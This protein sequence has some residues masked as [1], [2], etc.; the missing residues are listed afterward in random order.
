MF[1]FLT[2]L[3]AAVVLGLLAACGGED[4]ARSESAQ[5][6]SCAQLSDLK[7]AAADIGLQTGGASVSAAESLSADAAPGSAAAGYCLVT[8]KILPVDPLAPDIEFKVALPT[9]WNS[10]GLM[11]GGGGYNGTIPNV[12]GTMLNSLGASPL[13]R[14]YAVFA[15]DGGHQASTLPN[16]AAFG[17]NEEAYRN[18]MGDALKKTRDVA[19]VLIKAS[20]GREPSKSYFL[21]SSNGGREALTV[22]ARWPEDWD[23]VVALYP[24]RRFTSTVVAGAAVLHAFAE[25]GALPNR[26][27]RGLLRR[28]ALEA[29]DALDGLADGLIGN[30]N[31]CNARFDPATASLHGVPLRCAGGDDLGDSCLSDLQLS[32]L[33]VMNGPFHWNFALASGETSFPGWPVYTSDL[34]IESPIPAL[35][36]LQLA[37]ATLSIGLLPPG[38]PVTEGMSFATGI[39]DGH[40]RYVVGR[41][42]DFN[43]FDFNPY[44]GWP[45]ATRLSELSAVDAADTE[46]AKFAAKGGKLLMM[47]GTEDMT[48]SPRTSELYYQGLQAS[49][50]GPTVESFVRYYLVPGFA[51]SISSTFNAQWDQLSALE[52]W[53]ERDI[54]PRSNQIVIDSVGVPGRSRPLCPY[55]TFAKY[56]GSG[57]V[58]TAAS[59]VCA[60][61]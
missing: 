27:K 21:G 42:P 32:A 30:V 48:V 5:M 7:I 38:F 54:D 1:R 52:A 58:N 55:P 18:W 11:L 13:A 24:G 33:S 57:D 25:P 14:G 60:S 19:Q 3:A 49:L 4:A 9:N 29:C 53:V 39:V 44:T 51:H 34:G 6:L 31:A 10:K 26:A 23:G 2:V 20:Y 41:D 37:I 12:A 15:S 28:A 56:K 8:G 59:F 35:E 61:S 45:Y 17:L 43:Y 36:P 47:H 40:L 16:P 22:A 46:L 50:G